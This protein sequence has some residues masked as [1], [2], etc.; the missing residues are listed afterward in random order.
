MIEAVDLYVIFDT[1]QFTRR[2]WRTRNRIRVNG[3][4]KWLTI[5]AAGP[6][7]Q[8]INEVLVA[9]PEWNIHHRRILQE[10]Y[11]DVA[12]TEVDGVLSEIYSE[13]GA[14]SHLSQVNEHFIRRLLNILEIK[15]E[16]VRAEGLPDADD[17]SERLA[18]ISQAVGAKE[19]WS[20]SSAQA[21]LQHAPFLERDI[22]VKYFDLRRVPPVDGDGPFSV[23]H[24]LLCSGV[25]EG[26]KLTRF[27]ELPDDN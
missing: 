27:V 25:V 8:R 22:G 19:Y 20:G 12:D 3:Q 14:F 4:P 17:P 2:D 23:V 13:L 15:T 5:P 21:Y 9:D 1:V 11:R 26:R 18:R 24:D 16:L 10:A 6:R 7:D